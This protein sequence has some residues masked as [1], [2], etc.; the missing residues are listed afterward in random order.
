MKL[1]RLAINRLPGISQPFEIEGAGAGFHVVFGPNGIG[2]SSI[3]R[4]VEGLYW[5]DRCSSS[6]ASV[7]G[8]FE[9][10][11]ESW[12]GQRDGK[13]LTWQRGGESTV[14][15][16]LPP[17]HND[18]CFFLHLRDLIDPS[19]DGTA[20]IA[21]EIRRQMSGGFD[22]DKIASDLFP[23]V[24]PYHGRRQRNDFNR[25][26][27]DVQKALVK[28]TALQRRADEIAGL[29][30]RLE[31]AEAATRRLALVERAIGLARRREELAGIVEQIEALP[32]ALARMTG[33]EVEDVARH[34]EQADTLAGR[35]RS[36][37][38]DLRKARE[39]QQKTALESP[40]EQADLAVWREN[41]DE[42]R[43]IEL[44]L[45]AA[46]SERGATRRELASALS[47]IGRGDVDR[48]ALILPEHGELFDFLRSSHA[49]DARAGVIRERLRLLERVDTP[50]DGER[51]FETS[52]NAME[53]LR[54][55]L[56]APEPD[57]LANRLRTRWPWLLLALAM[58]LV[59]AGLAVLTG[60]SP[61]L[62]GDMGARIALALQAQVPPELVPFAGPLGALAGGIVF[63][64]LLVGNR[65]SSKA[66]RQAARAAFEELSLQELGK[67]DL[68]SVESRL[69]GLER[70]NA[71]LESSLQRAR[72]RGVERQALENELEGL[73]EPRA[74]LD[75]RRQELKGRLGLDTLPPD[76][77]LVD[78]A[79]ALDQV[80]LARGRDEAA[81][82]KVEGLEQKYAALLADVAGILE[83]HGEP[84]PG[85]AATSGARLNNLVNRNS[86]LVQAIADEQMMT[87][88]IEEHTAD[89]EATSGSIGRI[90]AEAA[91]SE[92]DLN[93]LISRLNSLQRYRH[94]MSEQAILEGQ[95]AL[96]CTELEKAGESVLAECDAQ[97]LERF[98][99]ALSHLE[100]RATQLRN[101][102]AEIHAEMNAAKSAN[103]M[104][105]V[106]AVREDARAN[107]R[108]LRDEGLYAKAGKFLIHAVEEE[109]EHTR[110][111]RIFER[112]RD[113][114]SGFTYHNYKLELGKGGGTP[115]LFA[116][117]SRSGEVR[118]LD[119]LSD[120]TRAQLLLAARIAFAEEAEQGK[121]L[122][123]FLDEAL[124]QSDP[125]RFEAIVRSLGC[126]ARD[127][128]RQIFYL[129]SD[130]LD[131]DRI[132]D[133]LVK[134]DCDIAAE[135]DL[136][137]IRTN[138]ASVSGPQALRVD[139][140]PEVP[141]PDGLSPEEYGAA[142]GVPAFRP[143]LGWTEQHF[144]YVLWDNP[145]LLHDFLSN[146]IERAGQW[147]TV[148][149]TP[150][151]ER[152]G[153]GSVSAAE[154]TSRL[155]L[156]EVFCELWKQGRGRSVGRDALEA[157]GAL[158]DHFLDD[159]VAIA[160][161]LD[162]DPER[163]L[164]ALDESPDPRLRGFRKNSVER[165]QRYLAE[166]GYLDDR[167][168]LTEADLRLRAR[169]TPAA[170]R[171]PAGVANDCLNHWW[172]W[173]LN[174]PDA[175]LRQ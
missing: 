66:A 88:Q 34:Q 159:V 38:A 154:I 158:T 141:A 62:L 97:S 142:L 156:L 112:A 18:R 107:L 114:F 11:G 126:V 32:G 135:I 20:D 92:G 99:D 121:V 162:G 16:N 33:K 3:C 167:P 14:S 46:R 87:G 94:L 55:W 63:A 7:N 69:R 149:G 132:R 64:V 85:D 54:S 26:S 25:A 129:T 152:L 86:R 71:I 61:A 136:G 70:E 153:S 56:R 4:A 90:Y 140:G 48:I 65:R 23:G 108:D 50:E 60:P 144:F 138:A 47:A 170:D 27:D 122:P 124:D 163:L 130:P 143:A 59:S 43:R 116:R 161:E 81:A 36:L 44:E 41:T 35:V 79:R 2:K 102:I 40:I 127:Q 109:Y 145:D 80:R 42:L 105:D 157:S 104:Q 67:W 98:K 134:E 10:D 77:E 100:A 131:V 115:R 171:L 117:E 101:E 164:A 37:E 125:Q 29:T 113:H 110:M 160:R 139:P 174:S 146:G 175:D 173:A 147:E 137:R 6:L 17:S 21:S 106:I 24:T 123:L 12:W 1:K 83:Q 111:P 57:S 45:D 128:G 49:N 169:T 58:L 103:V 52:R 53:A 168:V 5:E 73:S 51:D 75:A 151:A 19:R 76:A 72:D 119:E 84:R 89:R 95:I 78:F 93:G 91:L 13:R 120:G 28:Q 22:L 31:E 74:A 68:P 96:D 39:A 15:P 8:E 133:A 148:S 30:A 166:T 155:D 172:G 9:W 150:L 118:E 165:L 82:G